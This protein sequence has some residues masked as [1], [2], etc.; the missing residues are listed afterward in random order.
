M[1]S[2]R[3]QILSIGSLLLVA[4]GAAEGA[5]PLNDCSVQPQVR[6]A[7]ANRK[8]PAAG[9]GAD[10]A[11]CAATPDGTR[12]AIPYQ[13]MLAAG[14]QDANATAAPPPSET[15]E[16][17]VQRLEREVEELRRRQQQPPPAPP[18]AASSSA[19][20]IASLAEGTTK[21]ATHAA[22]TIGGYIEAFYQWNFNQPSNG[23]TNYRGFD[24]RHN[25]F[26]LSNAV[27]DALGTLGP[28]SAHV[29]LQVGHT[30]DT[31]YSVEP[32]SP[33]TAS[34]D[35]SDAAAWRFVQQASVAYTAPIG[36][37]LT[38]D[39][40]IFLS[41]IG[42]EGMAVK[43][44]WNWSRSDLFFGLP[45]YHTGA[46]LTYPF[47]DRITVSLQVYN[48]WNSVV[49]NNPE[50]S[51]AGQFTY[52]IA[53]R[54]TYQLLYFTGVERPVGAPE[55]RAWR[56]LFDSYL[57]LHP[58]P[59]LDTLVHFDGGVEP[60]NFG[61]SGWAAG[62]LYLRFHPLHW[63][64]L[65]ARG[66]FFYEWIARDAAGSAAP[67]FWGGASWV[68]SATATVD[69]RPWDNVSFR[70]EYRH[71]QAAAPLYFDG[72]VLVDATGAFVPNARSQDTIT[73]GATAW[74]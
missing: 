47:S 52:N 48:G 71:D 16:E 10:P 36:R 32:F 70:L 7:V 4:G 15:L 65:A 11:A 58:R 6:A 69:V 8:S 9:D 67:I 21:P 45:F 42:P 55:G 64:Y 19:G 13:D 35:T 5:P 18:P 12:D 74:F 2:V 49:D 73:L 43:D 1:R 31:Y 22:L 34:V 46:R 68:S 20:P 30:G 50:K 26:T 59:W 63:M 14:D 57:A 24:N 62:A 60:N 66:D 61:D 39:A 3:W 44:Q 25:T 40:G 41:P 72:Q 38:I 33:G 17:R 53:D 51:V 23:I 56:H 28:V 54:V 37:G 29:A 27:L